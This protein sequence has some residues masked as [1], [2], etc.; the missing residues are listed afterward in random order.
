MEH[1]HFFFLL[2]LLFIYVLKFQFFFFLF[3]FVFYSSLICS[4]F[5]WYGIAIELFYL[6]MRGRLW[7]RWRHFHFATCIRSGPSSVSFGPEQRF[8]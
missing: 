4:R 1:F 2:L 7:V 3:C 5:L 6:F 8:K